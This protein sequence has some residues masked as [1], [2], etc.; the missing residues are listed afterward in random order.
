MK[1]NKAVISCKR[2]FTL[3]ELLVVVLIIGILAAVALPQYKVAVAKS[4]LAKYMPL[5]KTL[6][7]A[8]KSYYLANGEYTD[9]LTALDVDLPMPCTY[10]T[11]EWGNYYTCTDYSIGVYNDAA[12]A[13]VQT[14]DGIAYIHFLKDLDSGT[15]FEYKKGD[16]ACLSKETTGRQVCKTLGLGT[17]YDNEIGAWKWAYILR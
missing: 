13:Q 2:G 5:V 11:S 14:H 9:D 17:E 10:H 16:I 6:V 4:R 3:I 15:G 12:S 7:E 8:E 1:S